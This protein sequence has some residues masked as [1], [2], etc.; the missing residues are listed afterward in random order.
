[1]LVSKQPMSK[2]FKIAMAATMDYSIR[3]VR[4]VASHQMNLEHPLYNKDDCSPLP[5]EICSVRCDRNLPATKYRAFAHVYHHQELRMHTF[6]TWT[7]VELEAVALKLPIEDSTI[8]LEC[9]VSMLHSHASLAAW[10]A[11]RTKSSASKGHTRKEF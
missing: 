6:L 10:T 8:R 4:F 11:W 1:M 7:W 3:T 2:S 5:C 9:H